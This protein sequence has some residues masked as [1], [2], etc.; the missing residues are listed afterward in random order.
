MYL[1]IH[2][3][4]Y[5][6]CR[7]VCKVTILT[8]KRNKIVPILHICNKWKAVCVVHIKSAFIIEPPYN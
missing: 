1:T 6:L 5:L 4:C 2:N 3:V 7:Y 8:R